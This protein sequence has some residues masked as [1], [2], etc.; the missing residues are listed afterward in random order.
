V[1][2]VFAA[3]LGGAVVMTALFLHAPKPRR[4]AA[5]DARAPEVPA[6]ATLVPAE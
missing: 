2:M 3:M 5:P 4:A 6:G 1:F